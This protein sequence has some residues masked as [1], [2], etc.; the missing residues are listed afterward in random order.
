MPLFGGNAGHFPVLTPRQ[1]PPARLY[2]VVPGRVWWRLLHWPW[3]Q[4]L[5]AV[6]TGTPGVAPPSLTPPGAPGIYVTDRPSFMNARQIS[7]ELISAYID[8]EVDQEDLVYNRYVSP[9]TQYV[10]RQTLLPVQHAEVFGE[11]LPEEVVAACAATAT[12]QLAPEGA[13]SL[14]VAMAGTIAL[15]EWRRRQG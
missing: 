11:G 6:V 3:R 13:E 7:A 2:R 15:H 5:A 9:L 1:S 12:I 10:R 14:N 4:Y 8:G